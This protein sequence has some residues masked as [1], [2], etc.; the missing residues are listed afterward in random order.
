MAGSDCTPVRGCVRIGACRSC[1]LLQKETSQA[2]QQL[3]DHIYG[4]YRIYH[5]AGGQEQK[6]R[7][8]RGGQF[9]P[10]SEL[11][12]EFLF[13]TGTMPQAGC[14]LDIGCGNGAFLRAMGKTFPGW[15]L[16]GSDLNETFREHI[17]AIG[18]RASF[19]SRDQL[20]AGAD[21]FD[22]VSLVHCIEHIP[23][24]VGYLAA[25]RRHIKATGLLLIEV[26]DAELNPFDMVVADHASHFSK[27]TLSA[28]VRAAGYE[29]IACGNLVVGKEITL[30]ARPPHD[31]RSAG[32]E[33]ADQG[34]APFARRNLA[35]LED[36]LSRGR[37]LADESRPFGICGT[38]IA[39]IW[40]HSAI[41]SNVD[42]FVDEDETR[43]G[44][45]YFG[46]PIL[47]P[48]SVP[49]GATVFVCLEPELSQ[50]IAARHGDSTR[51]YVTSP[52]L[53]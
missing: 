42:F 33:L 27:V 1:G 52:V 7:G 43:V 32:C 37:A 10:R 53:R 40:I 35:W 6:A 28:V 25:V 36:T 5:Q 26:P 4:G 30:L 48:A 38:S 31:A 14:V 45:K 8:P 18:A 15:R 23:A 9:A 16:T 19:Q 46:A 44:R 21:I 49:A 41:G 24:P 39:G 47:A 51:R 11:I 50:A 22:V 12:A 20:E 2:W 3:C 13:K 17:L 29:V 34:A